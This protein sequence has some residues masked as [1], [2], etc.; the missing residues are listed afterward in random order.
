MKNKTVA[1]ILAFPFGILGVHRFYLGQ[2]FIGILYML[3]FVFTSIIT[4]EENI[5]AFLFAFLI[6]FVDAILFYAMP[7]EDFDERYNKKRLRKQAALDAPKKT[8]NRDYDFE[9]RPRRS[10]AELKRLGI[11]MY[12]DGDY[13]AAA[14]YFHDALDEKPKDRATHFN[15][16][17]TYSIL[18]DLDAALH[19]L[20]RAVEYGFNDHDKI[21]T[22]DALSYV[23][24][25]KEFDAFVDNDFQYKEEA[26]LKPTSKDIFSTPPPPKEDHL[27]LN[28]LESDDLLDQIIR[29][30][31]LRDQGILTE[32]EF[33]K[34]KRK[35]LSRE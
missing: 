25:F 17:C 8:Y 12:R 13:E 21:F 24:S 14:D 34:Q 7:K 18:Q 1:A 23:R 29:L 19:H 27:E 33:D 16:A 31:E 26:K 10:F 30:G 4:A 5:P 20:D 9:R 3:M 2:R 15:L 11:E 6:P 35:I 32:E 22:H 28:K